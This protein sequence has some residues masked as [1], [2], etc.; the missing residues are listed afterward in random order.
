[1]LSRPLLVALIACLCPSLAA[2]ADGLRVATWNITFYAGDRAEQIQTVTYGVWNDRSMDPDVICLQEMTS[3]SAVNA[4]VAALNSAQGSPGDWRAAPVLL[5]GTLNNALVYRDSK[6]N[7]DGFELVSVGSGPPNH[8]RNVVRYDFRPAG[9]PED[10]SIISIFS[11]HFKAGSDPSDAARRTVEAGIIADHIRTLPPD[12]AVILGADLNIPAGSGD[13]FRAINGVVPNTGVLRDPI[14]RVG[15]WKNNP[16]YRMIHTQDPSSQAGMDDRYDQVLLSASLL[17]GRGMDYDGDPQIPWDL[18]RFDDPNH[19]HRTWGNDGTTFN[20]T[21]RVTGNAMVGPAIAQAIKDMADPDGHIPV[22]LDLD[23]PPRIGVAAI[24]IDLGPIPTGTKTPFDLLVSNIA[25]VSLWGAGG[26]APLRFT[27]ETDSPAL[28]LP[29]G[30]FVATAGQPPTPLAAAVLPPASSDPGDYTLPLE[31]RS[32]DPAAPVT[33]VSVR[34]TIAGCSD[35]DL[36][37]PPGVLNFF[38]INAYLAVFVAG[39]DQA[40]IAEPFGSI[41]FF[42]LAE[43][44]ATYARGC[45]NG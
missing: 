20:G 26:I 30:E 43:F 36:A 4:L 35:A 23:M 8:P 34:Y 37:A 33:P 25:D 44:L 17:D 21:L 15:T 11:Q 40:D 14:A 19:S 5:S 18:S 45:N 2:A 7:L 38:D 31:I 28:A 32:D 22:F 24:D 13:A 29:P 27:L 10:A 9:Y 41:D 42:D 3:R 6:L 1:M 12:R 39:S 16:T